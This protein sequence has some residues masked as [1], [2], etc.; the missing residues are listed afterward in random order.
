MVIHHDNA[1]SNAALG[2]Q[3]AQYD[4]EGGPLDGGTS[5]MAVDGNTASCAMV[6]GTDGDPGWWRVNLTT[7]QEV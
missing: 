3:T 4:G 1:G 2:R 6:N 5:G 7:P